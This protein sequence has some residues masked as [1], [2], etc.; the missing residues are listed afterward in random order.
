MSRDLP[1]NG[2]D[3]AIRLIEADARRSADTPLPAMP[4]AVGLMHRCRH[5]SVPQRRDDPYHR[6]LKHQLARSSFLYT[7][8]KGC[9][10][11]GTTVVETS[12]GLT[13][14]SD[15]CF[16]GMPSLPFISVIPAATSASKAKLIESQ[17]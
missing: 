1:Q 4:A 17:C 10:N 8:C 6:Q 9:I 13:A 11:E 16:A 5:R 3:N 15:F 12:S 2:T 14:V 7:L